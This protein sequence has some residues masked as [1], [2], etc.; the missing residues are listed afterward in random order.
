MFYFEILKNVNF[1][2]KK[3]THELI[4][5]LAACLLQWVNFLFSYLIAISWI[6]ISVRK[7]LCDSRKTVSSILH[8]IVFEY[9][10]ILKGFYVF[11]FMK[12]YLD[13]DML[14]IFLWI[15][16]RQSYCW[17]FWLNILQTH[18]IKYKN[19]SI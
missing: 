14:F 19:I 18:C 17:N 7:L 16:L 11:L 10:G 2:W 5:S 6:T 15:I 8:P 1:T 12:N 9:L 13:L 3:N 4:I